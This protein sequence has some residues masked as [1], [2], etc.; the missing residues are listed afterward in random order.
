[1]QHAKKLVTVDPRLLDQLYKYKYK[2]KYIQ[3]S[4][5]TLA[6]T[7]LSLHISR[8]L[9]DDSISEDVKARQY[10]DALRRYHNVK[11]TIPQEIKTEL[12]PIHPPPPPPQRPQC[13]RR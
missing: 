3:L 13:H 1:M 5:N 9:Q 10:Q 4:A 6:K 7:L 11:S 8:I 2:Y 12:N